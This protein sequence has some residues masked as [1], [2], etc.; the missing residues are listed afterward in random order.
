MPNWD[1]K[2]TARAGQR[3]TPLGVCPVPSR[4]LAPPLRDIAGQCPVLSRSVPHDEREFEF[5]HRM[6]RRQVR[7]TQAM[8]AVN[9][10]GIFSDAA[11]SEQT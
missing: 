11:L 9:R 2:T 6:T 10:I 5:E 7:R 8:K 3:D 4:H 1:E